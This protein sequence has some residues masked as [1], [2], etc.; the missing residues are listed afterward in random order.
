MTRR[1]TTGW[2]STPS[3]PRPTRSSRASRRSPGTRRTRS[4]ARTSP[5]SP[6][7]SRRC[8]PGATLLGHILMQC[9]EKR[10]ADRPQSAE[11]IIRGLDALVTPTGGTVP[12]RVS[13]GLH[14]AYGSMGA[15]APLLRRILLPAVGL[16]I[17]L[18]VALVLWQGRGRRAAREQPVAQG[19]AGGSGFRAPGGAGTAGA[20]CRRARH[21]PARDDGGE[22]RRAGPPRRPRRARRGT[23]MRRC[24]AAPRRGGGGARPRGGGGGGG[25]GARPGRFHPRAGRVAGG[26]AAN[27]GGRGAVLTASTIWADAAARPRVGMAPV[28]PPETLRVQEPPPRAAAPLPAAR[29]EAGAR[30]GGGGTDPRP[31]RRVRQGDR[32][33]QRGRDPAGVPRPLR[34]AGAGVGGVLPRRRRGGRGPGRER[35]AGER[36]RG[37]RAAAGVYVFEDPGTRRTRRESVGFQA[38]LRREG[39]RW[40]ITSL[41]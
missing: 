18:A 11:E 10:P 23:R 27:R 40:R 24:W 3:A 4:S 28:P 19:P 22:S 31:L 15:R 12:L 26:A 20:A 25:V 35:A 38:Q 41:R 8:A 39:G 29:A 32:V 17:A 2:T 6:A 30:A 21:L 36:G 14:G 37:G 16:V 5:R 9:L 7:P 34:G 33:A 13:S 1:W